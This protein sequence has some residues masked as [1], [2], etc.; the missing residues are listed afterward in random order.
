MNSKWP[1]FCRQDKFVDLYTSHYDERHLSEIC[2]IWQEK[3]SSIFQKFT[4]KNTYSQL[5][6]SLLCLCFLK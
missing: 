6:K 1:S 2:K 5:L 3:K 4:E